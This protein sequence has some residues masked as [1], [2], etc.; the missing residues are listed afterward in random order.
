M[1]PLL[2]LELLLLLRL[3]LLLQLL[4][5][6]SQSGCWC[7]LRGVLLLLLLWLLGM[8]RDDRLFRRH[9]RCI[10]LL[11]RHGRMRFGPELGRAGGWPAKATS[12]NRYGCL[13]KAGHK[14]ADNS[15]FGNRENGSGVGWWGCS[16][17]G[18]EVGWKG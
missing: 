15:A 8:L 11:H 18:I 4:L 5:L 10:I 9:L 6:G 1:L 12:L 14:S 7:F 13:N 17:L 16:G 3:L 2:P